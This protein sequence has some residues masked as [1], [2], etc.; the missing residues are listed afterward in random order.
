MK[1]SWRNHD[2]RTIDVA[3]KSLLRKNSLCDCEECLDG[4]CENCSDPDCD[5]PN[6][7]GS[8]MKAKKSAEL[9]MLKDFAL[10]LKSITRS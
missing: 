10:S 8:I 5:D 1:Y 6:C 7:E 9:A 2:P 4:D 3:L